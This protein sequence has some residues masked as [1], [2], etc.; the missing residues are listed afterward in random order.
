MPDDQIDSK[1][2][3]GEVT[4]DGR[5]PLLPDIQTFRYVYSQCLA[6][7]IASKYL[8]TFS[9]FFGNYEY[10]HPSLATNLCNRPWEA[11]LD[12]SMTR[13]PTTDRQRYGC[14]K[15]GTRLRE[16]V[17]ALRG[18]TRNLIQ[19][20]LHTSEHAAPELSEAGNVGEVW[21]VYAVYVEGE[22]EKMALVSEVRDPYLVPRAKAGYSA[23]VQH[24]H[25][26]PISQPL[27]FYRKRQTCPEAN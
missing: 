13:M 7:R 19:R 20:N 15:C 5:S 4:T 12:P 2:G 14:Q 3:E 18:N 10:I 21:R 27:F 11:R 24:S 17:F 26:P 6:Q 25:F 8:S 1:L 23:R 16:P 22:R 9:L